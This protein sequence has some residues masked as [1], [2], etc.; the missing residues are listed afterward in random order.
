VNCVLCEQTATKINKT[1]QARYRGEIAEVSSEL[2]RCDSC[3]EE[4]ATP[5][6]MR[7]HV[8]AVK[9]EIR[10]KHGLLPPERIA[11]IRHNLGLKQDELEELLGTGPKV[12]VRWESG[13]VIQSSGHD[14]TLRLLERDPSILQQLRTLQQLRLQEQK[15]Y[16]ARADQS[17]GMVAQAV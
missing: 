2:F 9:N 6:Q 4:F 3:N 15:E 16:Q 1:K 11:E 5:E 13:K 7:L 10:K 12:I 14:L 17:K 8:R